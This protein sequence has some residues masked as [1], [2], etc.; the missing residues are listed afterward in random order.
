M[1][2]ERIWRAHE[3]GLINGTDRDLRLQNVR[4]ARS[5]T[6]LDLMSRDLGQLEAAAAHR[7]WRQR[8]TRTHTSPATGHWDA[9]DP[10]AR[11]RT[12]GA[13]RSGRTALLAVLAVVLLVV[14]FGVAAFVF[15]VSSVEGPVEDSRSSGSS[16]A[17]EGTSRE[18]ARGVEVDYALTAAGLYNFMAAYEDKFGTTVV[19]D[20]ALYDRYA[21]VRT[22]IPESPMQRG[23]VLG[24]HGWTAFG[25]ELDRFPGSKDVDLRQVDIPRLVA[26]IKAARENLGVANPTST[27]MF[28]RR[29]ANFAGPGRI[30]IHVSNANQHQA[31]L[32][33]TLDGRVLRRSPF[34]G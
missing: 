32:E 18:R 1:L 33:T 9:F 24:R 25:P 26:N 31:A 15:M 20:L 30:D 21:V 12:L 7:T 2:A 17:F 27:W 11:L 8:L 29:L 10:Q 22:P 4:H 6:E 28:I 5:M 23:W 19:T 34:G 3:R 16:E 13:G 14:G